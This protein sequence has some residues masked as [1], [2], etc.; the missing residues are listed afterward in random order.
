ME[1]T[2]LQDPNKIADFSSIFHCGSYLEE[3]FAQRMRQIAQKEPNF[4]ALI[5]SVND[6]PMVTIN[7]DK[8]RT[9]YPV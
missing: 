6:D 7:E 8:T 1:I 3:M 4:I 5:R 9:P 2:R